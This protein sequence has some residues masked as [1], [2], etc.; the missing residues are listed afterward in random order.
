MTWLSQEEELKFIDLQ[1]KIDRQFAKYKESTHIQ[2][3][4]DRISTLMKTKTI[5]KAKVTHQSFVFE[6]QIKALSSQKIPREIT[7]IVIAFVGLFMSLV[8]L[9]QKPNHADQLKRFHYSFSYPISTISHLLL[10]IKT[11]TVLPHQKELEK[12]RFQF[13]FKEK[14]INIKEFLGTL[15]LLAESILQVMA[16]YFQFN[17]P[18]HYQMPNIHSNTHTHTNNVNPNQH[19]SVVNKPNIFDLLGLFT[20]AANVELFIVKITLVAMSLNIKIDR[21]YRLVLVHELVHFV[22]YNGKRHHQNWQE[23]F[24]D[25]HPY[26]IEGFAQLFTRRLM[27]EQD[28]KNEYLVDIKFISFGEY[29]I[30][31]KWHDHLKQKTF[32]TFAHFFNRLKQMDQI[33]NEFKNSSSKTYFESEQFFDDIKKII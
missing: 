30:Q 4:V 23:N 5:K 24:W 11:T 7:E 28:Y 14:E 6:Y 9:Y 3:L 15:E 27:H 1:Q 8:E 21:L 13:S 22:Q 31:E 2:R 16:T 12:F 29:L 20:A 18:E 19:Q 10:G 26:L 17:F 25:I 33:P 32:K